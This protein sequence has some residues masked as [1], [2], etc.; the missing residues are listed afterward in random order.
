MSIVALV[1]AAGKSSRMG[2][3]KLSMRL[4]AIYRAGENES[5]T[6]LPVEHG[7]VVPIN[8]ENV[9]SETV[10]G[11]VLSVL[12]QVSELA[13]IVVVHSPHS[14]LAW[15]KQCEQLR[16]LHSERMQL[17][18]CEQSELGMSY[19]IREGVQYVREHIPSAQAILIVLADQPLL[20]PT[21][22]QQLV[23]QWQEQREL[24]YVAATGADGAAPPILFAASMW[25]GLE[26]LTGDQ[27]ARRLLKGTD[28]YGA[29]VQLPAYCFWDADTPSALERIRQHLAENE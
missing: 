24:D 26:Q 9:K 14:S 10:G 7:S 11:R 16:Q 6:V 23:V 25:D 18:A 22:I 2:R 29:Q 5:S 4:Y 21:H 13:S 12:L 19:S 1:L 15:Q 28:W 27:G 17:V 20:E 3:D 8:H